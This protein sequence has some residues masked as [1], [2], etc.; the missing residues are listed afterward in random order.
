[1]FV[2]LQCTLIYYPVIMNLILD[3]QI[4]GLTASIGIEG[5]ETLEEAKTN[6]LKI[7]ANLDVSKIA[8]VEKNKDE[9]KKFVPVPSECKMVFI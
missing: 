5:A 2:A 9:L 7:C 8:T 4:V 6:I 1:M 3:F